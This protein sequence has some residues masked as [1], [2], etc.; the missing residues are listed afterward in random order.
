MIKLEYVRYKE[1]ERLTRLKAGVSGE[2]DRRLRRGKV[3]EEVLKQDQNA[4]VPL[5][6]QIM[7]LYGFENGLL[8]AIEPQ[9][10]RATLASFVKHLRLHRPD[11]IAALVEKKE[12]TEQIKEGLNEEIARCARSSV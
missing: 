2:V 5:E 9:D 4:P 12:L 10:V 8:D 1:L 3:L 7:V 11:L 6:E